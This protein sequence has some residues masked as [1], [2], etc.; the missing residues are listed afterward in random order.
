M[1]TGK[2]SLS[3]HFRCLLQN[4][5][6][7]EFKELEC[8]SVAKNDF[9]TMRFNNF[10]AKDVSMYRNTGNA[11]MRILLPFSTTYMRKS[12]FSELV[13]VLTKAGNKPVVKQIRDMHCF[14][15]SQELSS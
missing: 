10:W 3:F 1:E 12:S 15:L 11:A 7:E 8:N 9:E 5:M 13:S 4:K 14:Q 6:Q 2:K